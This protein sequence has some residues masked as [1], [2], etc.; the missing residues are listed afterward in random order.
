IYLK[1]SADR[2][3]TWDAGTL[4]VDRVPG[5]LNVQAPALCMLP[6][7]VAADGLSACPLFQQYDHDAV[8]L[9]RPGLHV[10]ETHGYLAAQPGPV[11]PGRRAQP[12]PPE[13]RP[14][15]AALSRRQRRS[16]H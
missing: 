13:Q 2:G 11:A 16:A 10:D 15:A 1:R 5:D 4:A 8:R 6:G 9:G 12:A 3:Q 7:G 14:A